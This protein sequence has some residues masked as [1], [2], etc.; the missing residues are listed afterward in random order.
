[1]CNDFTFVL[2]TFIIGLNAMPRTL[3]YTNRTMLDITMEKGEGTLLQQIL[4]AL[5]Q[6]DFIN[7]CCHIHVIL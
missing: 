6:T 4:K 3:Q 5:N 7:R 1:M 2:N